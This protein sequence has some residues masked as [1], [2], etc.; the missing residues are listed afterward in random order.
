MVEKV[1]PASLGTHDRYHGVHGYGPTQPD[2]YTTAIF[3]G[4]DIKEG[5]QVDS[6][7]L[8]DEAPTF[9]RLLNLHYP[10]PTAGEVIEDVL[11]WGQ[12]WSSVNNNGLGFFMIGQTLAMGF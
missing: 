6:A 1:D 2:Y 5:G 3:Y 4:P 7:H 11:K 10:Q 9:A 12:T 8:V